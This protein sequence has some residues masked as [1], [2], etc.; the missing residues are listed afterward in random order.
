VKRTA[1]TPSEVVY[2]GTAPGGH[3]VEERYIQLAAV[4]L[5]QDPRLG[6]RGVVTLG[7]ALQLFEQQRAGGPRDTEDYVR[8][9]EGLTRQNFGLRGVNT[10]ALAG[11]LELYDQHRQAAPVPTP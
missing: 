10:Q 7:Y 3:R 9:A 6:H 4:V 11:F 2:G 8:F 1:T 5:C